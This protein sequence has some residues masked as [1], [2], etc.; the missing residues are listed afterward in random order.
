MDAF[1]GLVV[2][3]LLVVALV[4][5]GWYLSYTA[6]RLDRLHAR[7]HGTLAQLD[8]QLVRRAEAGLELANSSALDPASSLL[9]ASAASEALEAS[10][11]DEAEWTA[12]RAAAESDLTQALNLV[13][14]PPVGTELADGDALVPGGDALVSGG[15]ALVP[16]R[17]AA[18][19]TRLARRFHNDAVT[20]VQRVR[21]KRV[22][23]WFRLAGRA[24]LPQTVEFDD[25]VPALERSR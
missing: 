13:L 25:E 15:D 8:A 5:I 17:Q 6:A 3:L 22:V 12:G 9:L 18:Q 7:A 11:S 23:R 20:D 10:N 16:L 1:S 14:G 24:P 4:A 21:G 19:R 2:L